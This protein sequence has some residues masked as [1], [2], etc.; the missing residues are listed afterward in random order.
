MDC[1]NVF[2]SVSLIEISIRVKRRKLY[3]RTI[4]KILNLRKK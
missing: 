1:A 2:Q 3:V 4:I